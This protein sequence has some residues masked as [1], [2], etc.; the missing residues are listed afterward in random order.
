MGETSPAVTATITSSSSARPSAGFLDAMR[1]LPAQQ[2]AEGPQILVAEALADLV[3]FGGCGVRRLGITTEEASQPLRDQQVAAFHAVQGFG[4]EL[5]VSPG[6]PATC[7]GRLALEQ[8]A[9][10]EPEGAPD[11]AGNVTPIQQFQMEAFT[12]PECLILTPHQIGRGGQLFEVGGA[13][14]LLSISGGEQVERL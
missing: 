4:V 14:R 1:D 11:G 7:S 3:G 13:Q 10:S 2:S 6:K 9:E 12:E 8:Q 5:A